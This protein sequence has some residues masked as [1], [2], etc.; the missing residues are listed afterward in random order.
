MKTTLGFPINEIATL[1]LLFMPPLY[2]FTCL[3]P[4]L[5]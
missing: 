1:S 5:P 3:L 4:T 2:F